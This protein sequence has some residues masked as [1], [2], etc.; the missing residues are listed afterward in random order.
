MFGGVPLIAEIVKY[1]EDKYTQLEVQSVW[2]IKKSREN[3]GFKGWQR[4][5]YLGTEVTTTIVVNEGAVTK[6]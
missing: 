2:L 6:N 4:D 5:F 1:F 3:D